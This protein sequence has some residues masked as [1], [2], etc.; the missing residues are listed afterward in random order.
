MSPCQRKE[1]GSSLSEMPLAVREEKHSRG[2]GGR[3]SPR[4]SAQGGVAGLAPKEEAAAES[5]SRVVPHGEK[6]LEGSRDSGPAAEGLG[7]ATWGVNTGRVPGA[8]VVPLT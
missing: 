5:G 6:G 2:R 3:A 4:P 7:C 1:A 8:Q